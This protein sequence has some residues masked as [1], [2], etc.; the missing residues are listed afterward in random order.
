MAIQHVPFEGPGL[1]GELAD[2]R[3]LALEVCHPYL[4][5]PLPSAAQLQGLIV[6][7][8]PMSV[9]DTAE[10][11]HLAGELEL[12]ACAVADRIPVLGVCLGAQLLAA[13]LGGRV[14]RGPSQEIGSGEI[15][16]TPDG[17]TDAVIGSSGSDPVPVFHW[18]GETFDLPD[19]AV[20]LARSEIYQNQAFRFG[21]CAYGFQFH[22][23]V[24]RELAEGWR[25]HLPAG[26]LI[27]EDDRTRI[28]A[29][30]R[31]IL[32]AF[33]DLLASRGC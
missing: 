30:G 28:E 33:F 7:G 32:T 23:E 17:V 6:M 24:N 2:E 3:G 20:W 31:S 26:V 8:G 11:P 1:I 4:G 10:H 19:G 16:L 29:A 27:D 9:S 22:V 15:A 18:H 12:I 25:A 14:Y 21:G 5:E 13:A